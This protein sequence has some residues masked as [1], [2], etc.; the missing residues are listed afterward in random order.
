MELPDQQYALD[1][2]TPFNF[3]SANLDGLRWYIDDMINFD[4]GTVSR[5]KERFYSSNEIHSYFSKESKL[6]FACKLGQNTIVYEHAEIG[7]GTRLTNS[8]VC[9][10]AKVSGLCQLN[11]ALIGFDAKIGQCCNLKFVS[12]G[13]KACI[14]AKCKLSN[15]LVD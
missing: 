13:T 10:G 7:E 8:V 11:K 6:D 3:L 15:V 12:I 4:A 5:Y 1:I 2:R 14:G 9:K